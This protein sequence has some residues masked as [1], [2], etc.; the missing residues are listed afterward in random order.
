M[1]IGRDTWIGLAAASARGID[2][3]VGAVGRSVAWLTLAMMLVMC[4]VVVLRYVFSIGSIALQESV[5]YLHAVVFMLGI[6]YALR[7][8][9]HVRIDVLQSRFSPRVRAGIELGGHLLF[10]IP[11]ALLVIGI[12][13]D[14]VGRSWARLEG[15]PDPGGLPAVFLLKSL[16]PIMAGLLLLQALAEIL[17]NVLRFLGGDEEH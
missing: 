16:I 3:L 1:A 17:R 8:G 12:S 4:L 7:E 14:Y 10:L 2:A 6:P 9:A 13:W 15:S 5:T 11:F